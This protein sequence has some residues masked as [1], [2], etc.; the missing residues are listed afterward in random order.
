MW[1]IS[2][3][4][5]PEFWKEFPHW[6][7]FNYQH[8]SEVIPINQSIFYS[9]PSFGGSGCHCVSWGVISFMSSFIFSNFSIFFVLSPKTI[10]VLRIVECS[11]ISMLD[12]F[13]DTLADVGI[14]GS[15]LGCDFNDVTRIKNNCIKRRSNRIKNV[16]R[17]TLK[18][19]SWIE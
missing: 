18:T 9:F 5:K 11:T 4:K 7:F 12:Y 10:S 3:K 15:W 17:I 16:S 2:L 1:V 19:V 8:N 13:K 6:D 14:P